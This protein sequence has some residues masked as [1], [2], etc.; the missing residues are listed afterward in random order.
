MAAMKPRTGDGPLE[1]THS[2][3]LI[4]LIAQAEGQVLPVP[5]L[6]RQR[7]PLVCL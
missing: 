6:V 5:P 3:N 4:E 1:V 7:G 2:G